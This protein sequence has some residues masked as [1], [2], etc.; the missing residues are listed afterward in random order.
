MSISTS[1][2][3]GAAVELK[4]LAHGAYFMMAVE[5]YRG[6]NYI[7]KLVCFPDGQMVAVCLNNDFCSNNPDERTKVIVGEVNGHLDFTPKSPD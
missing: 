6:E 1:V 4:S 2:K 7:Y 5:Y 3:H